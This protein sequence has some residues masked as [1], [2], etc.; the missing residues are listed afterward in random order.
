[1]NLMGFGLAVAGGVDPGCP[2]GGIIPDLGG[3]ASGEIG[4]EGLGVVAEV[5][6]SLDFEALLERRGSKSQS[7][8]NGVQH[9]MPGIEACSTDA[10]QAQI[11]NNVQARTR[12]LR[13][14]AERDE[15]CVALATSAFWPFLSGCTAVLTCVSTNSSRGRETG[16]FQLTGLFFFQDQ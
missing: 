12:G 16:T 13:P 6:G 7:I 9:A 14:V 8:G 15:T 1:M 2:P 11:A 10:H 5:A 4:R 3:G